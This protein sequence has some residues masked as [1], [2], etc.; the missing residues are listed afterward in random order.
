MNEYLYSQQCADRKT[1]KLTT[2]VK[3]SKLHIAVSAN[4]LIATVLPAIRQW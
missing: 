3:Q 4:H 2:E 1:K